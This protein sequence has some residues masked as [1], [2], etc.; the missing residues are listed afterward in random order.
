TLTI[1]ELIM[2][3]LS[4]LILGTALALT[5]LT[6]SAGPN[7]TYITRS[8]VVRFSDLNLSSD[9]GIRTLY[10]RIRSAAR[11]VCSEA[12]ERGQLKEPT[13]LACV[14]KAVDDAVSTLNKPALTAMHRTGSPNVNG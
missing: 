6:A 11:T 2:N 8:E 5:A 9:E 14:D 10:K 12:G 1:G 4:T 3:T 13:Y 7:G